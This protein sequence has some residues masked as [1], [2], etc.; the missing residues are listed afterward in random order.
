MCNI[1]NCYYIKV[2]G[3]ERDCGEQAPD[4]V[5]EGFSGKVKSLGARFVDC[6]WSFAATDNRCRLHSSFS[7]MAVFQKENLLAITQE[8]LNAACAVRACIADFLSI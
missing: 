2:L 7:F 5:V 1:V 3:D 4:R 6:D 8:K